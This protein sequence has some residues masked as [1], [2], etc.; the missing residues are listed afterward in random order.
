[1]VGLVIVDVITLANGLPSMTVNNPYLPPAGTSEVGLEYGNHN[2]WTASRSFAALF[3]VL[4]FVS[5]IVGF[6]YW[7]LTFY[8]ALRPPAPDWLIWF[9]H[10]LLANLLVTGSLAIYW[11]ATACRFITPRSRMTN[12]AFVFLSTAMVMINSFIF[13]KLFIT[14]L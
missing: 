3:A 14:G 12:Y 2:H 5:S 6:I 10:V 11:L 8:Y 4:L 13:Y 9:A 1:M 7:A